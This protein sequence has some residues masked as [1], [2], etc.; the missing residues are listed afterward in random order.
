[1]IGVWYRSYFAAKNVIYPFE[2]AASGFVLF[3]FSW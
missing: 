3:L 2:I 1:M